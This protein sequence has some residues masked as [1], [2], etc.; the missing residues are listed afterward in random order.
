[1]RH[2]SVNDLADLLALISQDQGVDQLSYAALHVRCPAHQGASTSSLLVNYA[3][4]SGMR[5]SC[6]CGCKPSDIL[7]AV[8]RAGYATEPKSLQAA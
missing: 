6:C 1:M 5:L 8:R 3:P 4:D 2:G 7:A